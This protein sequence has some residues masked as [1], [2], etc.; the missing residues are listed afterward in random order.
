[1]NEARFQYTNSRLDAPVNDEVGPAVN[2]AGVANFGTATVSPLARDINLFEAVDYVSTQRGDHALKFGGG[3]LYNRVNILFPGAVQGVYA[4]SSLNNFLNGNYLNYQQA[5][6]A[7]SQFQA[8][9]N[10]GVFVQDNG[11]RDRI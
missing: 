4:F 11:A 7:P 5:F 2:I 3:L 6:G 1:M 8:N 10:F 9:P